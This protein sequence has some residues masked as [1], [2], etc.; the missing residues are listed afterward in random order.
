MILTRSQLYWI[1]SFFPFLFSK[2]KSLNIFLYLLIDICLVIL[3]WARL[4]AL[5]TVLILKP[6]WYTKF[7]IVINFIRC[8]KILV[9]SRSQIDTIFILVY[10]FTFTNYSALFTKCLN[11][12][13]VCS[14]TNQW[15]I[16]VFMIR[17]PFWTFHDCETFYLF[18]LLLIW[19]V[20]IL[21]R[22][23]I[24]LVFMFRLCFAK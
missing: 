4:N 21:S 23:Q 16:V 20:E 3:S 11:F 24:A 6:F 18:Q 17:K 10:T 9:L 15:F 1:I 22:S 5:I 7:C 12:F 2:Y 19:L 14:R 8:L 13:L